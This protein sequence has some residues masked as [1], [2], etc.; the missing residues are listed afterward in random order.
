MKRVFK[1]FILIMSLFISINVY[2]ATGCYS[3][4]VEITTAGNGA[5][6]ERKITLK[7]DNETCDIIFSTGQGGQTK[8]YYLKFG[9]KLQENAGAK[10]KYKCNNFNVTFDNSPS[11][12]FDLHNLNCGYDKDTDTFKITGIEN[13]GSYG[14]STKCSGDDYNFTKDGKT[15]KVEI[16]IDEYKKVT[17]KYGDKDN[18][19]SA[20]SRKN[21]NV[22][23]FDCVIDDTTIHV[24]SDKTIVDYGLKNCPVLKSDVSSD[25]DNS[26][27]DHTS[28]D[29]VENFVNGKKFEVG[30]TLDELI[31]KYKEL[32]GDNSNTTIKPG[33]ITNCTNIINEKLNNYLTKI[34]SIMKYAGIVLC[35]GLTIYDFAKALLDSDKDALN[36]ITKRAL[37]RLILV[38]LLFFLPTLVNFLI[39]IFVDNPCKINF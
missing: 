26:S 14:T 19:S 35:I 17:L 33:E 27:G 23:E 30:G 3:Q 34:F 32:Y 6:Y 20:T 36:K 8:K 37:T 38:A 28:R 24:T 10:T 9:N 7:K 2:A 12:G 1:Y 25:L 18:F 13:Q 21:P 11:A 5:K 39:S 31:S 22:N 4:K 29:D 16:T 15:C